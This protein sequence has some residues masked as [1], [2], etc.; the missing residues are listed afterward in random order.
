MDLNAL[1]YGIEI[2][3]AMPSDMLHANNWSVGGYHRGAAIPGFEGWNTQADG[4]IR[5]RY[6]MTGVEV[7]SPIL[8]GEDGMAQIDAMVAKLN[9][10]GAKVNTSTGFHVHVGWTGTPAQLRRLICLVSH[11]EKALY[12]T[13]GTR[14][15][16]NG[17]YCGSIKLAMARYAEKGT[18]REIVTAHHARYH[19]LN[20]QNLTGK[21]TVEFRV[22]AGTLNATKIKTYVQICLGLV[23]KAIETTGEVSW[24]APASVRATRENLGAGE[25]AVRKMLN[26]LG[27]WTRGERKAFGLFDRASLRTANPMLR[28][29]AKKYDAASL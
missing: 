24:D 21:R 8:R 1:T 2:E 17:H 9:D 26:A 28:R 27:W 19:V 15:R 11:H 5:A 23:Q 18:E 12:A 14:A 3:T 6:P 10:M 22:F 25:L 20:L 16:E 13:T 29:L 7:V 4:S